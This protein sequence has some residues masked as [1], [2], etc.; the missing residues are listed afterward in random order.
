MFL[1]EFLSYI[2]MIFWAVFGSLGF[3]SSACL[4]SAGNEYFRIPETHVRFRSA[5][6]TGGTLVGI[7]L[8]G[9]GLVGGVAFGMSVDERLGL[10][11]PQF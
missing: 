9:L 10:P 5:L 11:P 1:I 7:A 8:V 2:Q 4:V 6:E 3:L